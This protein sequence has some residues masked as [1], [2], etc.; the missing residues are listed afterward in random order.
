MSSTDASRAFFDSLAE[1]RI[2]VCC[3]A[4]GV[5]KTTLSAA[6]GL[7][8][9]MEGRKTLV[10]TIDPAR[11]LADA[12]MLSALDHEPRRVDESVFDGVGKPPGELWAM[13]LD[14]K[15]TFDRLISR[16]APTPEMRRRILNNRYYQ[17][18]SASLAGSHEYMAMEKLHEIHN[19]DRFDL[20]VLDTP[21]TRSALDFLDAPR[22]LADLFA[23]NL[24]WK[25][26][27]P[28]VRTGLFGLKMIAFFA[29]PIHKAVSRVMGT[30]VIEEL[31][32]FFRLGDDLF[33]DGFRKRAEAIYAVL[34]GPTARFV[35][36]ASPMETPV[37]EARFFYEKLAESGMPFAGFIINRVHPIYP[38]PAGPLSEDLPPGL[39]KAWSNGSPP[40]CGISGR[41]ARRTRRPSRGLK[42]QWD[43]MS[44]S[45]RSP[46][47][48]GT[49]MT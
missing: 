44:R 32:D 48:R 37:R 11:R 31:L 7:W 2:V 26:V 4:G 1:A 49:C 41:W 18:L 12:L 40:T 35:A 33:F 20:I 47:S 14:T 5:G 9:A 27:R 13:M 19:E 16:F 45:S 23:D 8:G 15:H 21:P 46:G 10:L 25:L 42:F 3:G 36:V 34:S 24:F 6:L 39:S 17:H 38:E 22:R 30:T 28:Y 43:R 29:S